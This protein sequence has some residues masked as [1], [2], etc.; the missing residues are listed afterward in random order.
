MTEGTEK[1]VE[2]KRW[3]IS[4]IVT[5]AFVLSVL[6][7]MF[8][9]QGR[10][11]REGW[12][13]RFGLE[14]AQF[15]IS[16]VD[17]YWLALHGWLNTAIGW[18]NKA[19]DI[20]VGYLLI[21]TLPIAILM[22]LIFV[23]EWHSANRAAAAEQRVEDAGVEAENKVRRWL[24]AGDRKAWLVRGAIS[25]AVAPLSLA[26]FPLMLFLAGLILVFVI[27]VTVVPFENM[28]KQAADDFCKRPASSAA[29][30]VQTPDAGPP[31]W[32]YRIECNADVCAMIRDG[33]VYVIPTRDIQR[34]ELPA[35]GAA[36]EKSVESEEQLCPTPD[37]SAAV[38]A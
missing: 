35:K 4:P 14:S 7:A 26:A 9:L 17:I 11:Y 1:P 33:V 6:T 25:L 38:P 12:L 36:D 20:Y 19:W 21:L 24:A 8:L 34:I 28:G 29:R 3:R 23:W 30:I 2:R 5:S 16:T 31:E 15:P 37:D 10:A 27:A 13:G 22:F 32:G 18:F